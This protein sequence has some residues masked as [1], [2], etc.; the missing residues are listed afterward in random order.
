MYITRDAQAIAHHLPTDA[1]L[2]PQRGEEREMNSHPIQNSFCMNSYSME[3]P[4]RQFKLALLIL[5]P[6]SSFSEK[7]EWPWLCRALLSSSYKHQCVIS[8]V[9]HLKPK[10]TTHSK[11]NN[12]L[13]LKRRQFGSVLSI[14]ARRSRWRLSLK[15]CF[16]WEVVELHKLLRWLSAK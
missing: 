11:E 9:F 7:L 5:L 13:Q 2:A 15:K 14:P 16:V 4:F 6:P 12:P 3:Y 8:I 10:P 1:Q